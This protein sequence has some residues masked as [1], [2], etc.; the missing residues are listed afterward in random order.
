MSDGRPNFLGGTLM[1][2]NEKIGTIS[3]SGHA[4]ITINNKK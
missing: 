3:F 2:M 1:K 4:K